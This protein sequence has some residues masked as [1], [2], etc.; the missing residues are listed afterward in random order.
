MLLSIN[1]R[2]VTVK[3]YTKYDL[4]EIMVFASSYLNLPD[5]ITVIVST[6]HGN[7]AGF[8]SV[9]QKVTEHIY[10]ILIDENMSR[11]EAEKTIVHELAHVKQF[12]TGD[13]VILDAMHFIYKGKKHEINPKYHYD[14]PQE[15]D[16]RNVAHTI[17]FKYR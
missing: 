11:I 4:T 17:Y 1:V 12:V 8:P 9:T 14:E 15:R 6:S 13:L 10:T 16:A 3:D 2:A 7:I 5:T